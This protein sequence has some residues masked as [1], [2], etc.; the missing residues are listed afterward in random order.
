MRRADAARAETRKEEAQAEA[1]GQSPQGV[2]NQ[3]RACHCTNS[4]TIAV[5][6]L[7]QKV[8]LRDARLGVNWYRCNANNGRTPKM[9]ILVSTIVA[10]GLAVAFNAPAFAADKAPKTQAACEKA[11]MKWDA[12]S[13][14]CSKGS[15]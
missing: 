6:T 11:K 9:K 2:I 5:R 12:T 13:K 7:R 8:Q 10:L 1:R 15:M 14:T 3:A 4:I